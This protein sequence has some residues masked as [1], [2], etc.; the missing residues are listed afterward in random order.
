MFNIREYLEHY[1]YINSQIKETKRK[2]KYY[3]NHPLKS[4]HG[5][6]KGSMNMH[7]YAKCHF[8]ISAPKVKSRQER[9][10]AIAQLNAQ[11]EYNQTLYEDMKL[12]VELFIEGMLNKDLEIKTILSMKYINGLTDE[13]IGNQLGFERSTISK[14]IEKF[15]VENQLS[16]NSHS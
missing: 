16:H 11:L 6:V 14:K 7:P 9:D 8:V 3:R 1:A 2:L 13:Q 10:I 5:V 12:D 15:F 4:E